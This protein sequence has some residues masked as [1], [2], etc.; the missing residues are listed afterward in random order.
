[1]KIL[2]VAW[3]KYTFRTGFCVGGSVGESCKGLNP[4]WAGFIWANQSEITYR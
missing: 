4:K 1:M 2:S 3:R